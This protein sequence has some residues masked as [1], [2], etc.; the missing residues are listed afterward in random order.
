E[1]TLKPKFQHNLSQRDKKNL[2]KKQSKKL[3]KKQTHKHHPTTRGAASQIRFVSYHSKKWH[4]TIHQHTIE[5]SKNT[6]PPE[7]LP[8]EAASVKAWFVPCRAV[9]VHFPGT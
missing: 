3:A 9:P 2:T 7:L 1:K 5:F 4:Q 8:E 6:H